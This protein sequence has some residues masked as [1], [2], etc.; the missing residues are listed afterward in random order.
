MAEE[1]ARSRNPAGRAG[2]FGNLLAL[3]SALVAFL[4]SRA[5]LIARDSKVAL[6]HVGVLVALFV[7]AIVLCGFGYVFLIVSAIFG[8][9]RLTGISWIW[10]AL[11]TAGVHFA[12]AAAAAIIA[13]ARLRRPL[14][15]ATATEL[16]KDREWLKN[17]DQTT[18]Q[19]S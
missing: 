16:K 5:A 18:R 2:L 15:R 1:P 17:L 8:L 19:S 14:F 10:L 4:E 12:A 7:G 3:T 11:I 13:G 9:A 6:V